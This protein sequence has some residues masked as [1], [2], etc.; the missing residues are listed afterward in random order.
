[1]PTL[2]GENVELEGAPEVI[3]V[4]GYFMRDARQFGN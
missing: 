2:Q 3:E 4:E 1:M